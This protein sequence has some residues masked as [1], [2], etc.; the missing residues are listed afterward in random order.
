MRRERVFVARPPRD[1]PLSCFLR[2]KTAWSDMVGIA[3]SPSRE[4]RVFSPG[5]LGRPPVLVGR[6]RE[7]HRSSL[8]SRGLRFASFA[9]PHAR[10]LRCVR[11]P[12][13]CERV[14]TRAAFKPEGNSVCC[15]RGLAWAGACARIARTLG[16]GGG[17]RA[18]V[19][20][21]LDAAAVPPA[22]LPARRWATL[23]TSFGRR[24][25]TAWACAWG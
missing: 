1:V 15:P 8:S 11:R 18:A 24:T 9:S 5:V 4:R 12:E 16:I 21:C 22:L 10:A 13:P 23:A 17:E 2:S 20:T 6:A 25:G 3:G 7:S 14:E 19:P